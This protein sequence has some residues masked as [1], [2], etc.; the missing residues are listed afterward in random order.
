MGS[1]RSVAAAVGI[2]AWGGAAARAEDEDSRVERRVPVS[3]QVGL[4]D[5][6]KA[7]AEGSEEVGEDGW[8]SESGQYGLAS[9]LGV[10]VGYGLSERLVASLRGGFS[11]QTSR[12]QEDAVG[13]LAD[14]E[15]PAMK[16]RSTTFELLPSLRYV[17]GE[18]AVRPYAGFSFGYERSTRKSELEVS[19]SY[20]R[21]TFRSETTASTKAFLVGAELGLYGF[22]RG[23]VSLDAGVE[24]H[25]VSGSGRISAGEQGAA[26]ER[27]DVA[28]MRVLM[29]VGLS[30]WLGE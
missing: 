25:F 11:V 7:S 24:V 23:P 18:G 6:Q 17:L 26:R 30:A 19:D 9:R 10:G 29:T 14:E 1:W 13:L 12:M 15:P 5:Y 2:L 16:A 4:I 3:V 21:R 27:Y 8:A 20:T 22:V 28:G